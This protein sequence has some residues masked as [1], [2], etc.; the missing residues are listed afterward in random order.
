[1]DLRFAAAALFAFVPFGAAHAQITN[2]SGTLDVRL[3]V[4]QA[5]EVTWPGGSG[6]A[7]SAVLDFGTTATIDAPIDA[8]IGTGAAG[9]I[10]VRCNAGT[11]YTVSFDAGLHASGNTANRAMAGETNTSQLIPYQIYTTAGRTTPLTTVTITA[12]GSNQPI[13]IYGRV[14][15]L[16][17]TPPADT[18]TDTVTITISL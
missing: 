17:P 18:Y 1:M 6:G 11:E 7:G 16:T 12:N 15:V 2:P 3:V 5:C 14:P 9:G 10:E 4:T 8:D 13:P